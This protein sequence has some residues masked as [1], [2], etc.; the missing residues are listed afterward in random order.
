MSSHA[1]DFSHPLIEDIFVEKGDILRENLY[2]PINI[3]LHNSS[4]NDIPH[5]IV[6]TVVS[7]EILLR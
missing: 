4:P 2:N 3:G 6:L 5:F 7:F 1:G